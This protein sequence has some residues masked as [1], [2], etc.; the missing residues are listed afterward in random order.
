MHKEESRT[1]SVEEIVSFIEENIERDR[2]TLNNSP[3]ITDT[4][5]DITDYIRARMQAYIE[6]KAFIRRG[7]RG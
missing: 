5:I 4:D 7:K 2:L 3:V 6:V 1:P